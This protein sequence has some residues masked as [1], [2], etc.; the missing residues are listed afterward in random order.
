MLLFWLL[1]S[2]IYLSEVFLLKKPLLE[3]FIPSSAQEYTYNLFES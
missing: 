1:I 3:V 2:K